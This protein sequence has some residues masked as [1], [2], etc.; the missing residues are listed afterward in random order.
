MFHCFRKVNLPLGII[1]LGRAQL[2]LPFILDSVGP[3]DLGFSVR[4]LQ[5]CLA[6]VSRV[7][8]VSSGSGA[9]GQS[10]SLVVA[11]LVTGAQGEIWLCRG[12]LA[13]HGSGC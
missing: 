2:G 8:L 3:L 1:P 10:E 11:A 5:V 9:V 12:D 7:F 6:R 4:S 13:I